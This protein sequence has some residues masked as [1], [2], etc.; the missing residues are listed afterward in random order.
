MAT[1][2][3]FLMR[4][5]GEGLVFV[6]SYGALVEQILVEGQRFVLDNRYIVA[7]SDSMRY[8]MVKVA[9][10]LGH[11][12]LSGEGLVNRFSGPGSMLYQTRARPSRGFL[13]NILNIAT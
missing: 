4:T 10:S 2:G 13:Q 5:T 7:F 3:L 6:S 9:D 8:E 11:S 12:F 1:R